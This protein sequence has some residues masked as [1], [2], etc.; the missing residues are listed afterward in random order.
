MYMQQR[1]SAALFDEVVAFLDE[2]RK[3]RSP[4][5]KAALLHRKP[6]H[7]GLADMADFNQERFKQ[8]SFFLSNKHVSAC[9][10]A[11]ID[12]LPPQ[13]NVFTHGDLDSSNV[14]VND[15]KVSG[16]IDWESSCYFPA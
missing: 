5:V 10:Q 15:K 8:F 9:V 4:Y 13:P 12:G 7:S 1:R 11:R 2:M 6:L 3:L 16:I 14:L